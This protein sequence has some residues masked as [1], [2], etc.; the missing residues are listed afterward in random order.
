MRRS[1]CTQQSARSA[2]P[3]L[4]G[5]IGNDDCPVHEPLFVDRAPQRSFGCNLDGIGLDRKVRE[6]EFLQMG[7]KGFATGKAL[8]R[9]SKPG[10]RRLGQLVLAHVGERCFVDHIVLPPSLE[11]FEDSPPLEQAA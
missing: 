5:A 1:E 8:L 6:A 2:I 11:Q 10:D 9:V 4:A 7:H 3:E